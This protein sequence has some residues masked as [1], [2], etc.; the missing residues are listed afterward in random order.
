MSKNKVYFLCAIV[1]AF[2]I[3][4]FSRSDA[5]AQRDSCIFWPQVYFID[6]GFHQ[7]VFP[8]KN[9][10]LSMGFLASPHHAE[11]LALAYRVL[12]NMHTPQVLFTIKRYY[13]I[14]NKT[15][16]TDQPLKEQTVF[17]QARNALEGKDYNNAALML[18]PLTL[19]TPTYSCDREMAERLLGATA[20]L[21][22]APELLSQQLQ[23]FLDK[24]LLNTDTPEAEAY[25]QSVWPE[26]IYQFRYY[27]NMANGEDGYSAGDRLPILTE[28]RNKNDFLD[29]FLTFRQGTS[30]GGWSKYPK[31][32]ENIPASL[33]A[34]GY[35][36]EKWDETIKIQWLIIA[37]AKMSADH[38]RAMEVIS[39][40]DR[41]REKYITEKLAGPENYAYP[42]LALYAA[43]IADGRGEIQLA[44]RLLDSVLAKK[45][46]LPDDTIRRAAL[47][48]AATA[49]DIQSLMQL[50]T[51]FKGDD[52]RTVFPELFADILNIMSLDVLSQVA[53][54]DFLHDNQY[55][56]VLRMV[57][58]RAILL[59]RYDIADNLTN[60]LQNKIPELKEE[61][62]RYKKA[63]TSIDKHHAALLIIMK[64]PGLSPVFTTDRQ[65]STPFME[66]NDCH[67]NQHNW[68]CGFDTAT[69]EYLA[70]NMLTS[71]T[72][73]N[74]NV[75]IASERKESFLQKN[76]LLKNVQHDE[77]LKLEKI[78][79]AP[80]YF[81]RETSA[82]MKSSPAWVRLLPASAG[83]WLL[84][85]RLPEAIHYTI[86]T[87]R[88]GCSQEIKD[89]KKNIYPLFRFL[90]RY[91]RY[92]Y[93]A[94]V[95]PYWYKG[96]D[97]DNGHSSFN[98]EDTQSIKRLVALSVS[99]DI[100][101]SGDNEQRAF[102]ALQKASQDFFDKHIHEETGVSNGE[103]EDIMYI[104]NS[105]NNNYSLH[106]VFTKE[107]YIA[108]DRRLN[109]IY[110]E[111]QGSP[112][113]SIATLNKEGVKHT[114]RAWI[115][116]RDA[117]V[118]FGQMKYPTISEDSWKA[119]LTEKRIKMLEEIYR[120]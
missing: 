27:I 50:A 74:I 32:I 84:A 93:W 5:L 1:M 78:G 73:K 82:W 39:L 100:K 33:K 69:A 2:I 86:R 36:L 18:Q 109:E 92:S 8:E 85:V 118:H 35:A 15:F 9:G 29:W 88:Y 102:A 58:T 77:L 114:Q 98:R 115:R 55:K 37:M 120:P 16:C 106:P 61:L 4:I 111:I 95:T 64:Y 65:K 105:F 30:L 46:V 113:L 91:Y 89:A 104:V 6:E 110:R 83:K 43:R 101:N 72:A 34:A 59:E 49:S 63:E 28:M 13:H 19:S 108:L 11:E 20:Y 116:Y 52:E 90:K 119:W 53:T 38:P 7:S 17:D 42:S 96:H 14:Q 81:A 60:T 22:G 41:Y 25:L 79:S 56:A 99:N 47:L 54:Y 44:N 80:S 107:Q 40:V 62:A 21:S 23:R 51:Y 97:S 103:E 87:T 68:W 70:R 26:A 24:I 71:E 94:K 67:H 10:Q 12:N 117:W 31:E 3:S 48:R 66:I 76:A 57:W 45:G 75:K 112:A